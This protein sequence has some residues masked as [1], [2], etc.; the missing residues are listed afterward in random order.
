MHRGVKAEEANQENEEEVRESGKSAII[1]ALAAATTSS[2]VSP[3]Q[4]GNGIDYVRKI[5]QRAF[6]YRG[7]AKK[8]GREQ[9]S[10]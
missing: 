4:E 3:D 5:G 1:P 10:N 7:E 6:S 2:N 9:R 8:Q